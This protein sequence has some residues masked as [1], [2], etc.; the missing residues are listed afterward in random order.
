VRLS[1]NIAG[2]QWTKF[3]ANCAL[4]AISA[5]SRAQYGR[6]AGDTETWKLVEQTIAEV[7][8]VAQA[9]G[10]DLGALAQLPEASAVAR[11]IS[12]QIP[13][14]FSSTAQ[15][16][17]HGKRTEIDSLNGYIARRGA[18]L[19]VATP[20]NH[21]LWALVKLAEAASAAAAAAKTAS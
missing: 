17:M 1:A 19:G 14:A 12:T 9:S 3:L 2:D 13:E 18:A 10:V 4:N 7:L 20:M 8:A 6:I 16:L 5:L 15:D 11:K 21:A